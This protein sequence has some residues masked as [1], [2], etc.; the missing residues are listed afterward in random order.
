MNELYLIAAIS[1]GGVEMLKPRISPDSAVVC[2]TNQAKGIL[3]ACQISFVWF[4][5]L[6]PYEQDWAS[7]HLHAR[8]T[9][10][11]AHSNV[12][13]RWRAFM[14]S[15]LATE[16][17]YLE[18]V[19]ACLER[20]CPDAVH[21]CFERQTEEVPRPFSALLRYLRRAAPVLVQYGEPR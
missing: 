10:F 5:E 20:F 2:L 21:F 16:L 15:E 11:D 7:I 8:N 9:L 12:P 4:S 3:D 13:R 19:N 1:D 17:M 14:I 6:L 18:A